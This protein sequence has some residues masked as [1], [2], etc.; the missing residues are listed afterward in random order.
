MAAPSSPP[1]SAGQ[2]GELPDV[3][4]PAGAAGVV[5]EHLPRPGAAANRL[6]PDAVVR[7]FL[8]ID[9]RYFFPD[10]TLAFVDQGSRLKVRTHNLEVVHSVVA[11][12]QARGWRAIRLKGTEAF[13][14]TVWHEASLQGIAVDGYR[15]N[16][17]DRQLLQRAMDRRP[18]RTLTQRDEAPARASADANPASAGSAQ[19]APSAQ[20]REPV[21][22]KLLAYAPAPYHFDPAERMSYYARVRTAAGERTLWGADLE[23]AFAESRSGVR[24]GDEV[25]VRQRGARPVPVRLPLR[26]DAGE[27]IGEQKSIRQRMAWAVEK[28]SYLAT[29]RQKAEMV[30]EGQMAADLV[31]AQHPDLAGALAGLKLAEQFARRL[32]PREDEQRRLVKAIREGMADALARGERVDLPGRRTPPQPPLPPRGRAARRIGDL[33]RTA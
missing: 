6:V 25:T 13:R 30:R 9:D 28:S 5:Q 23:R 24:V 12:M 22:G 32:T 8:R 4:D 7:R 2:P 3:D 31:L 20:L 17:L 18:G 27:L 14:R 15:A 33:D 26:N 16:A 29:L 19:P 1:A 21:T 11:I 10:R